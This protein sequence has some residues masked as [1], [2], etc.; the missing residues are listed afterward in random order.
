LGDLGSDIQTV[1]KELSLEL[2]VKMLGGDASIF[3]DSLGLA[4]GLTT[5]APLPLKF[6]FPMLGSLG[7]GMRVWDMPCWLAVVVG[8]LITQDHLGFIS[9]SLS[10]QTVLLVGVE[11]RLWDLEGEEIDLE[12]GGTSRGLLGGLWLGIFPG[13]DCWVRCWHW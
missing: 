9:S 5:R 2:G 11:L 7:L 6:S 4:T 10:A 3:V 12:V 8:L 13:G 1:L